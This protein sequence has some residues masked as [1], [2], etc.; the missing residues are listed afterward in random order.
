MSGNRVLVVDDEDHILELARLYLAREGYQIETVSDGAQALARFGQVKPDLVVLDIMLPNVDGLT[1]CREIR[2]LSQVPIIMLTA[3]DEVTDKVVGLELGADDYLTKP[4]HPQELVARAKALVRRAR[5]EPDQPN[6][7][8]AGPLEVDLERHEVRCGESRVQL[9]P[10]EFD[11]LALLARH[12]GRVFQRSELLDL[13]WGYDF[14]G[15]TRT[16]DVHVQQLREKLAQGGVS[17]PSI[18]TVWGVGYK[19]EMAHG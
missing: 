19:L 16:V 5:I 7:V 10:K 11:L 1:I 14:P 15:Y 6:L 12:P 3:R 4:F 8:R 17:D 13:V 18:Q 2:K 9:R